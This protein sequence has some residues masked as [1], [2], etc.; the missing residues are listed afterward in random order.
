MIKATMG[1]LGRKVRDKVTR[2]EGIVT[3]VSFDLYGCLMALVTPVIG[4]NK[5]LQNSRW[6]DINRL[7][8][9]AGKRV[10][11]PP[12]FEAMDPPGPAEK[13]DIHQRQI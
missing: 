3:S 10:M 12:K 1:L 7:S 8:V 5:E 9:L 11:E 4:P 13:P 2:Q 6:F